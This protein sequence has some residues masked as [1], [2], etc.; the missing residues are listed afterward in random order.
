MAST[1]RDRNLCVQF[2]EK[3][4]LSRHKKKLRKQTGKQGQK[5][6]KSFASPLAAVREVNWDSLDYIMGERKLDQ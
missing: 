4:L 6:R 1:D 2:E 5:N 3:I